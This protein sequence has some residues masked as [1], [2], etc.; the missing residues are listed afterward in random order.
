MKYKN[1]VKIDLLSHAHH[2]NQILTGYHCFCKNNGYKLVIEDCSS[3]NKYQYKKTALVVYFNDKILVYD[4]ADGYQSVDVIKYLLEIS[5]FYFKRS[6]SNEENVKNGLSGILP[7]GMNYDVTYLGNPLMKTRKLGKLRSFLSVMTGTMITPQKIEN[8]PEYKE[9]GHTVLFSARLWPFDSSLTEAENSERE[10]IN[11]SRIKIIRSLKN[12]LGDRFFG[13]LDDSA[14]T[15]EMAPDLILS[16]KWTNRANYIRIMKNADICI[17]TTGL[18]KSIGGKMG[19]YVAAGKAIVTEKLYY[20]VTG[21]FKKDKNYLEFE[22]VDDCLNS[23]NYLLDNPAK[24]YQ[25][26]MENYDYYK[27]FLQPEKLVENSLI[28]AGVI[29]KNER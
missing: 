23:V 11:E 9:K 10:I 25:M 27:E 22:T 14:L 29:T 2:L 17:A 6:F 13:G 24:I 26:Q 16:K 3:N 4:M 12:K 1:V 28:K 15:R 8:I 18:H 7:L 19:E 20:D 5:D 21:D